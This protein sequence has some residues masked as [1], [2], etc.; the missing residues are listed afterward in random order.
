MTP[1]EIRIAA[2]AD[3]AL[4]YACRGLPIGL[5]MTVLL[6][7]LVHFADVAFAV[8]T[9]SAED[10][11]MGSPLVPAARVFLLAL[12]GVPGGLLAGLLLARMLRL[13]RPWAVS[14]LGMAAGGLLLCAGARFG[15]AEA[16]PFWLLPAF[17]LTSA[18]AGAAAVS[19][20]GGRPGD[21]G[22]AQ[23]GREEVLIRLDS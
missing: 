11:A 17:L 19:A 7:L 8:D 3:R 9:A 2:T 4:A 1:E 16:D 13:P 12:L 18:Y 22:S 21:A 23:A 5:A 14:L 6:A 10:A 20:F 15:M